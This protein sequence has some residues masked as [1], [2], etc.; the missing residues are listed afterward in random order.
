MNRKI[1]PSSVKRAGTE[2]PLA[3]PIDLSGRWNASDDEVAATFE[4]REGS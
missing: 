3:R 1:G 2:S 4:P